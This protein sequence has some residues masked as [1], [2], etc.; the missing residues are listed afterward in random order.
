MVR[1]AVPAEYKDDIPTE[2]MSKWPIYLAALFSNEAN[3]ALTRWGLNVAYTNE[4]S[5]QVL[6][7]RYETDSAESVGKTALTLIDRGAISFL[8]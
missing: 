6:G 8:C 2:E 3:F 4:K 7:L 1:D 5:K